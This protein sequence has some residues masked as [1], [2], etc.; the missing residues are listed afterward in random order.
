MD[1][2]PEVNIFGFKKKTFTYETNSA[3]ND[4]MRIQPFERNYYTNGNLHTLS[5][6]NISVFASYGILNDRFIGNWWI[7]NEISPYRRYV[8]SSLYNWLT[9]DVEIKPYKYPTLGLITAKGPGNLWRFKTETEMEKILYLDVRPDA[10]SFV[11]CGSGI[12]ALY[13]STEANEFLLGGPELSDDLLATNM[14]R[15]A[16]KREI[17]WKQ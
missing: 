13:S 8:L 11:Y 6:K 3:F 17:T 9:K 4:F 7:N 5:W 16:A 15:W 14:I 2:I 10:H 12:W 1:E